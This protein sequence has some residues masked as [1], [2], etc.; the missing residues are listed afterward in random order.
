MEDLDF[1]AVLQFCNTIF[2]RF[3]G[4]LKG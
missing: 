2:L 1:P 3:G 4:L